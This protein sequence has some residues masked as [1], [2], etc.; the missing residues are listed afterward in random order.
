M[1]KGH[2]ERLR[3]K[4][5]RN[6]LNAFADHEV[7]ELLLF[8]ANKRSDTNETAHRLINRFGSLTGVLEASYEDLKET[9]EVGDV[10]ATLITLIPQL[11][12]RY[13]LDKAKK[14]RYVKTSE[15]ALE[16]FAPKFYG[17]AEE[18]VGVLSVDSQNKINNFSFVTEGGASLAEI[19]IR[20]ILQ[21]AI[22]SS[23]YAVIIAHNHPGGVAAPSKSD[24][25]STQALIEAFNAVGVRLADHMILTDEEGFSMANHPKFASMFSGKQI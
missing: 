9:P 11:F 10:A 3:E 21:I 25:Q 17:L 8:Y 1:H 5:K 2:R 7:L 6:G 19:D 22:R 4:Y 24:I 13:S 16:F 23:A 20:Q 12:N 18:R 14:I 15:E